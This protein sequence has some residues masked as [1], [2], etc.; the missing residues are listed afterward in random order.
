[1]EIQPS[2]YIIGAQCT[3]KTTLVEA[4]EEYLGKEESQ[5]SFTVIKELARGIL[6][7]ASVNR[8]DIRAGSQ[9][10]RHFQSL[11]LE[12][13]FEQEFDSHARGLILSDRSGIDP[14]AYATLYCS[15]EAGK[16]LCDKPI[17]VWLRSRMQGSLV[18]LCEPVTAWLFDDGTR[19]MPKDDDEWFE[20]HKVFMELL[21]ESNIA[22]EVLPATCYSKEER[23]AFVL[24]KWRNKGRTL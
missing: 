23:M 7:T 5:P 21:Q 1:M 17:W 15:R 10:A 13:Q 3:G 19:L 6:E 12:G 2:I 11:V 18:V 9:K 8:D 16:E 20:L 22:F 14:I 24:E 4:V